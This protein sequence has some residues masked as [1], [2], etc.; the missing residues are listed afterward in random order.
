MKTFN[1]LLPEVWAQMLEAAVDRRGENE[2]SVAAAAQMG[3]L[4]KR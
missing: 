1:S 4:G 3:F 2:K